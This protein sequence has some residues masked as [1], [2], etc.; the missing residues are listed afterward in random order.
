MKCYECAKGGKDSDAVAMCVICGMG[1]CMEHAIRE[2]L[3]CHGR[4]R[5]GLRQEEHR[6]PVDLPRFLCSDCKAAVDVRRKK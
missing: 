6:Y 5:L 3:A 4:H 1:P 2:D